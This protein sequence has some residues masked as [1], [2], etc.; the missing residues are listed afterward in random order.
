MFFWS[1]KR[2]SLERTSKMATSHRPTVLATPRTVGR[3]SELKTMRLAGS[4]PGSIYGRGVSPVSIQVNARKLGEYLGAHG[5]GALMD[6][7]LNGETTPVVL[8]EVDRSG[9][10]GDCIHVGFHRIDMD[11]EFFASIPL[12]FEGVEEL[13]REG[14]VLQQLLDAVELHGQADLLPERLTVN[15][16]ACLTGDVIHIGS[17]PLPEGVS[18]TKDPVMAAAIITA[19]RTVDLVPAPLAEAA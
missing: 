14:R 18:L 12:Y 13:I 11:H 10:S 7:E 5:T 3:K 17:I 8:H 16:A 2:C 9:T 4:I 1:A 19:P 6:L 15:V